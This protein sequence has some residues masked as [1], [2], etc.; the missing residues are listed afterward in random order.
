MGKERSHIHIGTS[1]W[2]YPHWKGTFYPQQLPAGRMLEYYAQRFHSV[3]VNGVFYHLPKRRHLRDWYACTPDDFLFSIK[4]SRYITHMKK[5]GD[6]R[7]TVPVL[8]DRVSLLADKLGPILFQLPPRW[9]FNE[10]RLADF[11]DSLSGEFRYAFEFRDHSWLNARTLE[12]L[13]RHAAAFCI[14]DLDGFLA[15]RQRTTDFV[16]LRLHGPGAAYQG[17]YP[18]Q[19]LAGWAGACTAWATRG[20]AV[21]CYFDNDQCGYAAHNAARLQAM[22][23]SA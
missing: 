7:H 4:A 9:H 3:E 17:S 12:L 18:V 14:Y 5:L 13:S 6:P 2:S 23:E 16:Y 11:L 21:Y 8:L 15:P 10:Q 19:T 20:H 1:G 22:L